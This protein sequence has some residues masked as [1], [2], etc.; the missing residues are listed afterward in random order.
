M[1]GHVEES[2]GEGGMI[3]C[4]DMWR[5]AVGRGYDRVPG[6]VEESSGE[7]DMIE[8]QDMW[9]KAVGKGVW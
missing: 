5:K 1:S 3:E 8:C 4:Q 9:R 7:G 6:H 2:S